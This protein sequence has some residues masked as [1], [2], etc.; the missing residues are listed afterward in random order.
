MAEPTAAQKAFA[1]AQKQSQNQTTDSWRQSRIDRILGIYLKKGAK[2][3]EIR[4]SIDMIILTEA[5]QTSCRNCDGSHCYQADY[6]P[7]NPYKGGDGNFP[8]IEVSED[9][10]IYS[11][12]RR[13]KWGKEKDAQARIDS[14][15][16]SSH[17][18]MLYDAK[19]FQDFNVDTNNRSAYK[20]AHWIT[21]QQDSKGRGLYLYGERGTGKTMLAS[22]I[23]NERAVKGL[24]VLF[25]SVPQLLQEIRRSY[26]DKSEEQMDKIQAVMQ[27]PFAVFDDLGAERITPWVGE[28]LYNVINYRYEQCLQTVF[29]S[30]YNTDQLCEHF[31]IDGNGSRDDIVGKRI[32]SR[33]VAMCELVEMGG[34]D[35]RMN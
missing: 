6:R 5:A 29:T 30:N 11:R 13:C 20:A 16:E 14:A 8:F 1:L 28:Q 32:V 34:K 9:G 26:D 33:I 10:H 12:I 4:D 24:P 19:T 7:I 15:V 22:I 18:P 35:R 25:V 3:K 23:A 17:V 31:A 21:I 2:E 27:A